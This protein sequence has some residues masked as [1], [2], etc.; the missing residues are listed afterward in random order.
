MDPYIERPG[1][2]PD[3]HDRLIVC[4][5]A[6]L[7][8]LLRPRYVALGQDRL[9]VVDSERPIYPDVSVLR[10]GSSQTPQPSP[11]AVQEPD[12]PALFPMRSEEARQPYLEIVE[13]AAGNRV[14]TAIEVLS[15]DNKARGE[16]RRSYLRKRR[17][18]WRGRANLVE[19]DL[20]RSGAATV[21]VTPGQMELLRPWRY[22]A[23]VSRR[24][25]RRR[26]VY[27][28]QLTDRLPRVAIPLAREDRD[29][30]LDVQAAFTRCYD[31]GHIPNCSITM[32]PRRGR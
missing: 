30:T 31:E 13:P 26:E 16:G 28:V 10:T 11:A 7:Q 1:L 15:P 8:P 22:L 17:E 32:K 29:V 3:F 18:L 6:A 2:W 14:V 20:L 12:A 25:P 27:A 5:Q 4:I 23:A 24:S 21:N 9:F 19:I